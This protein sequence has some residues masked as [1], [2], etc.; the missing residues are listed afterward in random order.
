MIR[1]PFLLPLLSL[2]CSGEN[3]LEK[4]QNVAPTILISSH[5][6]GAEFLDGYS[7]SFRA[8][9]SDDDNEFDELQVAWYVGED[10]VC[11]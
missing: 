10:I 8:I 3:V 2:A 4:Q 9:V 11:D 1:F 6:D 7:E 5:S